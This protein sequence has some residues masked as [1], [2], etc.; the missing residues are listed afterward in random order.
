M[1]VRCVDGSV[2][3]IK[4]GAGLGLSLVQEV[5]RIKRPSIVLRTLEVLMTHG[6]NIMLRNIVI[7]VLIFELADRHLFI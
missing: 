6:R 1:D 3:L 7:L 4:F 5:I 2:S